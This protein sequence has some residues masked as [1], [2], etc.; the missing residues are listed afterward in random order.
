MIKKVKDFQEE[1]NKP[2]FLTEINKNRNL[3]LVIKKYDLI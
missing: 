3:H 1:F 2:Y